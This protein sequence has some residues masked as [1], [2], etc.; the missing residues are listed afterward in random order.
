MYPS[1]EAT[2]VLW[3]DER[4][5]G[6]RGFKGDA[7][8]DLCQFLLDIPGESIHKALGWQDR[9]GLLIQGSGGMNSGQCVSFCISEAKMV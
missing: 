3:W 7:K 8:L 6:W 4:E 5:T 2:S 9:C 1:D